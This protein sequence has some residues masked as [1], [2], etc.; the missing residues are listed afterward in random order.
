MNVYLAG[1]IGSG[2]STIGRELAR[3]LALGFVDL[4]EEMDR[5][6]GHSFHDLVRD[7]GWLAFRELEYDIC[8]DFA[9]LHDHVV[10]LGGGTIRYRW[11]RDVLSGT[12][13]V[14]LLTATA[15]TLVERV[16]SADRPRVNPGTDLDS[17]VRRLWQEHEATYRAAADYELDT[18]GRTLEEEVSEAA[19]IVCCDAG[20]R[21]PAIDPA[22]VARFCKG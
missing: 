20:A 7:R 8:R 3:E 13:I 22:T 9:M 1:M 21:T 6:L 16:R 17:D 4:D 19:R 11:N 12:G 10:C 15:E 2:K 5:R 18:E 14:I